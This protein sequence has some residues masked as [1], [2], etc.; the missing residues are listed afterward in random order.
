MAANRQQAYLALIQQLLAC[1]SGAEPGILQANR[2]LLDQEFVLMVLAVAAQA[3]E[4]GEAQAAQFLLGL[5]AQV[6]REMAVL[7][8][9]DGKPQEPEV[10]PAA[11]QQPADL[12]ALPVSRVLATCLSQCGWPYQWVAAQEEWR[13]DLPKADLPRLV[14]ALDEGGRFLH[15]RLPALLTVPPNHPHAAAVF[16]AMLHFSYRF[17][18][19]R[20]T[21]DPTDGE[22]RA[23]IELPLED[24]TATV[25]QVNRCLR[26][27]VDLG[28]QALTVLQS[29]LAT[30]DP[31]PQ[32]LSPGARGAG[33]DAL[34]Q[35]WGQLVQAE[36]E[37]GGE[38][39]AVHGVMRQNLALVTPALGAVI[40]P[41]TQALVA[42]HPDQAE[43]IVGI[44]EDTCT[45][46][47]QFP[48]GKYAEVLTIAIQGYDT[49]LALRADNPEKRSQTLNNQA[50]ARLTQAELGIDPA[51]NLERA[52]AAY[53]E[54]A[55]IM[56]RLGL[57][58]DLATTL[59]NW[60]NAYQTL[61]NQ[62]GL[63]QSDRQQAQHNAIQCYRQALT[64]F[65]PQVLPVETL[66]AARALGNLHF[67]H[68]NWQLALDEGY[69]P[70]IAAVE[71]TRSWATD[72]QRRQ[73]VL[74]NAIDVYDNALQC[75][76]NLGQ[77]DQA[78]LLT[79]RARARHLVDLMHS[80]DL[81]K[82]G[83][84]PAEMQRYLDDYETLQHRIDQLRQQAGDGTPDSL[85]SSSLRSFARLDNPPDQTQQRKAEIAAQIEALSAQKQ[86]V[87]AKL[88]S[89]DRVLAEGLE[90]PIPQWADLTRLLTH[91]PRTAILSL[92]STNDHTH[93]LI[94]RQ[95]PL[96][97]PGR[98]AG[99]EGQLPSPSGRGAGGE[100]FT[101]TLHTCPDQG[102]RQLQTWI[103]DQWHIPY[104]TD[105][106][107]WSRQ[108]A[109]SL[110]ELAHRLDL[111]TLITDHLDG[112]DELI[113]IPHL[114]LHLIP[115]AA[116]P[117]S[118][119]NSPR[120]QGEGPGVRVLGDRFRIRTLPS[121]QILSYCHDRENG[122]PTAPAVPGT[123]FGTV[124]DASGDRPIVTAGFERTAQRLQI[125]P[126]QRLRGKTQATKANYRQLAQQPTTR[127]LHSIHHAGSNLGNPLNSALQLADGHIT[128]GQLLSPGW[129]LPH[130]IEV[131]LACCETNLG[132]PNLTDDIL[133]LAS[134]FLCAG[135]RAVVSTL[136]AVDALATALFCDFYYQCRE[137]GHDRPTALWQAQQALRTLPGS[138]LADPAQYQ[139]LITFYQQHLTAEQTKLLAQ[140]TTLDEQIN[141]AKA[142]SDSA[143]VKALRDKGRELYQAYQQQQGYQQTL[144][145]LPQAPTPF[146]SP[147]YWAGFVCQ[148]LA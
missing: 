109:T 26:G 46:V 59:Y 115:F 74:Q 58:R 102:Y 120:P 65:N 64:Y 36:V 134:G 4:V 99:G 108:M 140:I 137:Q 48:H 78:I 5:A 112:I 28:G 50:T 37:S 101:C 93:L 87:W 136:W 62:D 22:V 122:Q 100:G 146:A 82:D 40:G 126:Q 114:Y 95:T 42:Q 76:I 13:V 85:A 29:V 20:L 89:L 142:A 18:M 23:E 9:P 132:N 131:F 49:V 6:G 124:E 35:F 31:H 19:L 55:Q 145:R 148:G 147:N 7:P 17:K 141:Q 21:Y 32:P 3:S 44:V 39:V 104:H 61:A 15:F 83:Q 70:A 138:A 43:R 97:R 94:L 53:E 111:D 56:R 73:E 117:I 113:L 81:Y 16:E 30:G 47:W 25:A 67:Q 2:E 84:I 139:P 119:A 8:E 125:P 77:Y 52:I 51:P 11:V 121:A 103:R 118:P 105:P 75:H 110:Q 91:Q 57:D 106:D 10:E 45:S 60:G 86:T 123:H 144:S 88:R 107:R 38:A 71:Q 69:L 143:K 98:G 54:S 96:S 133:T 66:K 24:M 135:A 129:R 79:E 63:S 127:A 92:Y 80:H 72:D 68:G 41:W 1:P 116:L 14:I 34:V 12:T 90:V 27:V 33:V 130:L 128:L